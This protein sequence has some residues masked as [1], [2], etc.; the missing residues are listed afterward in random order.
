[1][2]RKRR[3]KSQS[4]SIRVPESLM[5]RIDRAR[6]FEN[7]E[8]AAAAA[9]AGEDPPRNWSQGDFFVEAA[10]EFMKT[11]VTESRITLLPEGFII[12]MG[13]SK[14]K[15]FRVPVNSLDLVVEYAPR[16]YHSVTRLLIWA[17][18]LRAL[19]AEKRYEK[20]HGEEE[21]S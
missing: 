15:T 11:V 6:D 16:L 3:P 8:R 2:A 5:E 17:A 19:E 4:K 21:T 9:A 14:M 13:E 10:S 20:T 7:R 1:M 12:P 18:Y